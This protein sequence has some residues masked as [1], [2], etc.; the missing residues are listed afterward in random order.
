MVSKVQITKSACQTQK[1]GEELANFLSFGKLSSRA[2]K[3]RL[4][5]RKNG[6]V[7]CLYGELGSGKTT[8]IQGLARGLGINKRIL[9][10]AFVFIRPYKL[11]QERM[12]YH[13]DLYRI[14]KREETYGLGLIEFWSD[15]KNIVVIEWADKIKE[16]LPKERIDIKFE[17]LGENERR[18]TISY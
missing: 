17:N 10:P 14:N 7:V 12:F 9:S 15:P 5:S 1:L 3:P 18:I 13:V 11:P 6:Q 8:F 16:I 4:S 2:F